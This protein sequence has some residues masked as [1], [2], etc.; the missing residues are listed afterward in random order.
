MAEDKW[1]EDEPSMDEQRA[2]KLVEK[3]AQS[4][5]KEQKAARRWGIFFKLLTFCWLFFSVAWLGGLTISSAEQGEVDGH[6]ALVEMEGQIGADV[7]A[8]TVITGLRAAFEDA[9]T[10]AVVLRINSPGGSP[11][12]SGYIYDEMLRLRE[13]HKEIPLYAVIVDLGAS[14]GYYVA[15]G[16]QE[17]YANR[18]SL[19]GSI[20][21]VASSFGFEEVM[22]KVGVTRRTYTAGEDKAFL[23]PF[24]PVDK[25]AAKKWQASLN[26]VHEQFIEAVEKGRSGKLSTTENLFTGM[27]WSGEQAMELGLLD[28]LGSASYVARE[29]VKAPEIV[30][31]TVQ[32]S[33]FEQ[34]AREL[35]AGVSSAAIKALGGAVQLQ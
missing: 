31:F 28:G 29:V 24:S 32:L 20:G 11:V 10:K 35:G 14:G 9:N 25:A 21:V 17:I 8:D 23:D 4:S 18:A 13:L 1:K 6:T 2:W 15:A 3:L 34:F 7:D 5:L 16:A 33:P 27:I 30:D 22:K 26:V 12:Q 19:V